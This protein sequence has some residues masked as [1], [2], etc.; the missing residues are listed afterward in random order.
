MKYLEQ[1]KQLLTLG[2]P[3]ETILNYSTLGIDSSHT[4]ELIQMAIDP[5]LLNTDENR[6]E[7]TRSYA[8]S[9]LEKNIV[10]NA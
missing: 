2:K 1:V 10:R 5:D 9:C 8:L 6:D 4:D 3:P 7:V